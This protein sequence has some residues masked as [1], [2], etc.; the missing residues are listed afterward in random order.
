MFLESPCVAPAVGWFLDLW[1][2][3][4]GRRPPLNPV[5]LLADDHRVWCPAP[6]LTFLWSVLRLTLLSVVWG[7]RCR[8]QAAQRPFTSV[9]VAAA[10]VGRVNTLMRVEWQRVV[11]DP[12]R[13]V[14]AC[15]SLFRG[16][17]VHLSRDM[18][19]GRWCHRGVLCTVAGTASG[20]PVL[21]CR[22]SVSSPVPC[23]PPPPPRPE[24]A[25]QHASQ[26]EAA[27]Q[28]W[29]EQLLLDLDELL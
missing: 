29:D 2:A 6:G 9:G 28:S 20:P 8:R 16:T 21:R 5:V 27:T 17:D 3:I 24:V 19:E 25:S 23:P 18:F 10:M 11:S 1:Q 26:E 4:E 22:L 14:G 12:R 15:P 13:V 7:A